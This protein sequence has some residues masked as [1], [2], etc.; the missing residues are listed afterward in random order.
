MYMED[1]VGLTAEATQFN[2]AGKQLRQQSLQLKSAVAAD[3]TRP[4]FNLESI[5]NQAG[6]VLL[7]LRLV[8][9]EGSDNWY[10]LPL[11]QDVFDF[12]G[13]CFTGCKI[14]RFANMTDLATMP[15]SPKVSIV[16]GPSTDTAE[17]L[18]SQIVT[19]TAAATNADSGGD[20]AFF[21][22]LRALDAADNDVLPATWTDNFLTLLAGEST[23]VTL[24][25]EAG[26]AVTKVTA[27]PF[28]I[29]RT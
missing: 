18:R 19:V 23:K 24:E 2:L 22:R 17:G 3:G 15:T 12:S 29:P 10:W 26:T 21:I 1:G 28:N 9:R 11:Q 7:R 4:L 13:G 14:D 6:T 20:V 8:G 16:L 27:E 5:P 25:Y